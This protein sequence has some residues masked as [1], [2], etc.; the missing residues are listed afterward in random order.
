MKKPGLSVLLVHNDTLFF[1]I[2]RETL[3]SA[4]LQLS[5]A[6]NGMEAAERI[7][8]ARP[9]LIILDE[10]FSHRDWLLGILRS[11]P[12]TAEIP[13]VIFPEKA[14][15]RYAELEELHTLSDSNPYIPVFAEGPPPGEG[16][17]PFRRD[18][19][20]YVHDQ[21]NLN[22]REAAREYH[23]FLELLSAEIELL[24]VR[25][26]RRDAAPPEKP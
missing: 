7:A 23:R 19:A 4:R 22:Q 14:Q 8:G 17:P 2:R 20:R 16:Y 26:T 3:L 25:A 6:T 18:A 11:D 9:H 21:V 10:K 1:R 15:S 24:Q 13:V 5:W 12:E